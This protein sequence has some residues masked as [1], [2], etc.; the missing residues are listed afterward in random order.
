[1]AFKEVTSLDAD[2]AIS[3]GGYNKKIKKENPTTAQGFYLG[4][5]MVPSKMASTG[6]A[7][8]HVL[9]T[10]K[11]NLGVWGK[12]D[13]DR[14]LRQVEPGTMIR[15]TQTGTR[16][17]NKGNDAY[18]FKVEVDSSQTIDVG[19]LNA[20]AAS[21]EGDDEVNSEFSDY[22]DDMGDEEEVE[23]APPARPTR[24]AQAAAAPDAARQAKVKELLARRGSKSA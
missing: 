18:V 4:T 7:A 19:N 16:P 8:L 13:L 5:R 24:P 10:P 23:E 2:T 11:G 3:L 17:T 22:S 1:M 20:G 15:I 21:D 9:Q 12:A 6:E 14:K